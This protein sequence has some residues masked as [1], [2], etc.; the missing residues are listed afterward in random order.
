LIARRRISARRDRP[1]ARRRRYARDRG[2][3]LATLRA[4]AAYIYMYIKNQTEMDTKKRKKL[5]LTVNIL[6]I[7][8]GCILAC[9]TLIPNDYVKL[10]VVLACLCAG[11]YRILKAMGQ[12]EDT[13]EDNEKTS[14]NENKQ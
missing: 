13:E 1:C 8:A 9:S 12:S 3:T 7:A 4:H 2:H 5:D 6:L 11:L 14:G 10:L